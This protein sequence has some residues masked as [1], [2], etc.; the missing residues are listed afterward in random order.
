MLKDGLPAFS[1]RKKIRK[2][3]SDHKFFESQDTSMRKHRI[4]S[5]SKE[6]KESQTIDVKK[7]IKT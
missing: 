1:S 7:R 5:I 2:L 3:S 6:P 4:L